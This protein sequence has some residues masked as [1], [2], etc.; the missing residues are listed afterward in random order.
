LSDKTWPTVDAEFYVGALTQT[1][2]RR[3]SRRGD[4]ECQGLDARVPLS[5]CL[6]IA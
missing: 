1:L 3:A 4:S 6:A 2:A 5:F